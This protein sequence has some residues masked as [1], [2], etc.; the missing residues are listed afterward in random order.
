MN[1]HKLYNTDKQNLEKNK[2][3]NVDLEIL[4]MSGLV[5][6]NVLN[7]KISE[8][9]EKISDTSGLVNSIVLNTEISKVE[10]QNS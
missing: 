5:T 1:S 10:K 8:V 3:E 7:T 6:A 9:D 2:S 4:D